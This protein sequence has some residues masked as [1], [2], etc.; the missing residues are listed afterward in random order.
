MDSLFGSKGEILSPSTC[1][2]LWPQHRTS[3]NR[4]GL[5]VRCQQRKSRIDKLAKE[6]PPEG[7][8][9]DFADIE[10]YGVQRWLGELA[11]ALREES[12]SNPLIVDQA[13]I[14]AGFDFRRRAMKPIP[15]YPIVIG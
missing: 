9:Q 3:L 15:G 10:A 5:S 12:F 7:G 14:K 1:F 13:A 6:K 2:P 4:V 8:S 11:L